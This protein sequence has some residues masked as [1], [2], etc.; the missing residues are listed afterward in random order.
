MEGNSN[1]LLINNNLLKINFDKNSYKFHFNNSKSLMLF[2]FLKIS[3]C[4]YLLIYLIYKFMRD[5]YDDKI[6]ALKYESPIIPKINQNGETELY[7]DKYETNIYNNIKNKIIGFP[8]E[9][10][11]DNQREFL[12]VL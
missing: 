2:L 4:I 10:M 9:E 8:C 7:L 3:I 5:I 1:N 6:I 11:W 12:M